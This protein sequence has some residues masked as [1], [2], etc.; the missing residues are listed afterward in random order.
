MNP[1]KRIHPPVVIGRMLAFP[2]VIQIPDGF[3][4]G[5]VKW[6]YALGT[7]RKLGKA[8][9]GRKSVGTRKRPEV[10]VERTILLK[11]KD[12]VLDLIH[13]GA[14]RETGRSLSCRERLGERVPAEQDE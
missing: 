2:P 12:H 6:R 11:D 5:H 4:L 8:G 9:G 3:S 1:Y 13:A 10:I 7:A 14:R